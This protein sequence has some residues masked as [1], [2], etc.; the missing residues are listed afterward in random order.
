VDR[1]EAKKERTDVTRNVKGEGSTSL[2]RGRLEFHL[3]EGTGEKLSDEGYL[4]RSYK[5]KEEYRRPA[6]G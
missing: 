2:S 3:W 1:I 6:V 4:V 5:K